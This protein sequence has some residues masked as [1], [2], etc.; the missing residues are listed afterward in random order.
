MYFNVVSFYR[1]SVDI[2]TDFVPLCGWIWA[3][4]SFSTGTRFKM[5]GFQVIY[6]GIFTA[7]ISNLAQ[8]GRRRAFLISQNS[9]PSMYFPIW[10]TGLIFVICFYFSV[11]GP[12]HSGCW[13]LGVDGEGHV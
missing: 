12:G 10:R 7:P 11:A 6:V 5:V 4:A 9:A 8:I 13:G 1:F 2:C 3:Y